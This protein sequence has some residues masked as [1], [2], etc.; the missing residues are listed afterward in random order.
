[1]DK[2]KEGEKKD[3]FTREYKR[4]LKLV[5]RSKLI[6]RN[7]ISGINSWAVAVIRYGAGI[8]GWSREERRSLDWATR[9]MMTINGVL[10]PIGDVDRLFQERKVGVG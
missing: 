1:M 5:L 10:H 3:Q 2:I 8:I 9:K 7:K 6:D 4:R